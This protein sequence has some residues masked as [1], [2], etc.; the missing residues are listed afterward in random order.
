MKDFFRLIR[1]NNLLF[2]TILLGVMDMWVVKPIMLHYQLPNPLSW[3]MMLLLVLATVCI[4]AAGYVINDYFDVKIDAINHPDTL[5]ITR[6]VTKQ[7][8]M[9]LFI[10][11]TAVGVACGLALGWILHSS[12]LVTTFIFIPGLLWFYSASYKRQFL[13]G[14]LIISF[15]AGVAP[16]LVAIAAN[17]VIKNEYGDG[18]LAMCLINQIYTYIGCFALLSFLCT[19]T[20]E[21]IKDIEDQDGD[22]ELECHTVPVRCGDLGARIFATVL[23]LG[24]MALMTWINFSV[25]PIT[26]SWSHFASRFYLLLMVGFVCELA[27][28]WSAK[29]KNDYHHAQQLMKLLMFFGTMFA[30]CVKAF[31]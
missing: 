29:V 5:I 9:H 1:I 30:F 19:W 12:A 22:R 7:Q 3:W 28:L 2:I 17:S 16:L 8:A 10:G 31:L 13:V 20:R 24:T 15:L 26:F 21:I 25:L 14:N 11:L 4:A 18:A 6:S 27:L 23:M